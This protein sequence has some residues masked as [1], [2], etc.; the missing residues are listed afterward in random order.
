M[1][2]YALDSSAVLRYIDDE[3]GAERVGEIIKGHLAGRHRVIISAIHWGELAGVTCKT[4]GRGAVDLVLSRLLGLG[5]E[6]VPAT[7][8]RAV[9]A[10]LIKATRGLSYADAF[11]VE[12]ASESSE[13]ILVTADFDL[14]P[15][16]RDVK[17]EF[18]PR[19]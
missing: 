3:A 16:A 15:A 2:V 11:G 10:A 5:F 13:H 7:A 6:N 4:R 18:L 1:V 17:I 8:E 19:E 14:K 12:L 9:R